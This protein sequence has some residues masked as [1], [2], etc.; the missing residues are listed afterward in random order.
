[1]PHTLI[2]LGTAMSCC[3]YN[4]VL[5][6]LPTASYSTGSISEVEPFFP[7]SAREKRATPPSREEAWDRGSRGSRGSSGNM[8]NIVIFH[9]KD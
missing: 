7:I 9:L 2:P 6:S 1:M 3:G 4:T 8:Q 5:F